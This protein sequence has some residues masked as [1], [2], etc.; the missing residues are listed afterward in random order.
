[1][2]NAIFIELGCSRLSDLVDQMARHQR[3]GDD[4]SFAICQSQAENL[5]SALDDLGYQ[6]MY[7][8]DLYT[9]HLSDL[10]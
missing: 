7:L 9:N 10:D 8:E 1:M 3:A 4:I 2:D 5:A 6:A